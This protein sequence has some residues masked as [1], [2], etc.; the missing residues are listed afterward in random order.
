MNKGQV[1]PVRHRKGVLTLE[2]SVVH[3]F[4]EDSFE[5][6]VSIPSHEG[7]AAAS[8]PMKNGYLQT[9]QSSDIVTYLGQMVLASIW[10]QSGSQEVLPL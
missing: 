4:G 6:L 5:I 2:C 7:V 10:A 9:P 3:N 1:P 8:W